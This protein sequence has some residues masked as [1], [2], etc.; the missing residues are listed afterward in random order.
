MVE[1]PLIRRDVAPSPRTRG[2]GKKKGGGF[3]NLCGSF[4]EPL[5]SRDAVPSP[6]ARGEGKKKRSYMEILTLS[7]EL[8][9]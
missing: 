9:N 4:E 3:G 5:I 6:R 1:D 8:A 2:E 7:K